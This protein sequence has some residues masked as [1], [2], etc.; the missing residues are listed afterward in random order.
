MT[1]DMRALQLEVGRMTEQKIAR[2]FLQMAKSV[3]AC[4]QEN[5]IHRDIKLENFLVDMSCITSDVIVKLSD[6]GLACVYEENDP[7]TKKCGSVLGVAPEILIST[8][9]CPKVDCW[10]LGVILHELL[11]NVTPFYSDD[12][13]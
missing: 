4:H 8:S 1:T 12:Q 5:I 7:P 11:T 10:G 13:K 9:Y 2:M 6:F 3:A